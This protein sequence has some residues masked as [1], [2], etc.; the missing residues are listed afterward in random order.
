MDS[1]NK[2][3]TLAANFG[4]IAGIIF[5][6]LE[7]QQNNELLASDASINRFNMERE[8]RARVFEDKGGIGEIVFKSNSNQPLTEFEAYRFAVLASDSLASLKWQFEEVRAG[9]LPE[10]YIDLTAWRIVWQS[11]PELGDQFSNQRETMEPDLV[12]FIEE[13][14]IDQ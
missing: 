10:E 4:V 12:R 1:V 14:I 8:R 9:R 3:L 13:S 11:G 5:L 2:W 7:L 6:V